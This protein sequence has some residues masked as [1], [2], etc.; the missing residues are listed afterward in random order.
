MSAL[1]GDRST[2]TADALAA[3]LLVAIE[4]VTTA[5]SLDLHP[6]GPYQPDE[7][8]AALAIMLATMLTANPGTPVS[9]RG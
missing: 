5:I 7:M 2:F 1:P 4:R 6:S 3:V 8:I 9:V